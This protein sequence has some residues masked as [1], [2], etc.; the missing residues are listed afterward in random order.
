M[1]SEV[2]GNKQRSKWGEL[3]WLMVDNGGLSMVN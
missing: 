2:S 1:V 3:I